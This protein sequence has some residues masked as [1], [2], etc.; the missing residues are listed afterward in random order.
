MALDTAADV[1]DLNPQRGWD[2]CGCSVCDCEAA[3]KSGDA[4]D[5]CQQNYHNGEDET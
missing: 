2:V 1:P 3:S 4:C 5:A